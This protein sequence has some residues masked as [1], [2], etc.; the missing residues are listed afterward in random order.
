MAVSLFALAYVAPLAAQGTASLLDL[1][2][3]PQAEQMPALVAAPAD[4]VLLAGKPLV[5]NPSAGA[6][7]ATA[8]DTLA[9]VNGQRLPGA[10]PK[11]V[12][13]GKVAAERLVPHYPTP[14]NAQDKALLESILGTP[15][16]SYL[17][18]IEPAINAPKVEGLTAALAS[19]AAPT[20]APAVSGE[21]PWS[22]PDH[23]AVPAALPLDKLDTGGGL[24][25]LPPPPLVPQTLTAVKPDLVAL[26][27]VVPEAL[28]P[29]APNASIPADRAMLEAAL[30]VPL[31]EP[32]ATQATLPPPAL[33]GV[34]LDKAL[35]IE[36]VRVGCLKGTV[37]GQFGPGSKG[38][39]DLFFTRAGLQP[40][41]AERS[42][43]VL[44]QI[45]AASA[46]VCDR[47]YTP[48]QTNTAS[49]RPSTQQST[50]QQSTSSKPAKTTVPAKENPPAKAGKRDCKTH[51]E[52]CMQLN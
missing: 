32:Y 30:G 10:V 4:G 41:T 37:D 35:Q 21:R 51:P 16:P 14:E 27:R 49:T 6:A 5:A 22:R 23:A 3:N 25:N 1:L 33:T 8:N 34:E 43:D 42:Q 48:Q 39:L 7:T 24:A 44:N 15:L 45:S 18:K 29:Y 28:T 20:T 2:S 9:K 38:A 52:E 36:L 31:P 47:P 40:A 17:V 12:A 46:K 13:L 50:G 19:Q 26:P 11:V